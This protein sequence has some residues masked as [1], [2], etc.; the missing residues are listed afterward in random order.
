LAIYW[1]DNHRDRGDT[2]GPILGDALGASVGNELGLLLGELLND[3][4]GKLLGDSLDVADGAE[5]AER[6]G[7]ELGPPHWHWG[8]G[9]A[10]LTIGSLRE[11]DTNNDGKFGDA[12][13]NKCAGVYTLYVALLIH[14]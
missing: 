7:I 13:T 10:A 3:T 12:N 8:G 14:M 1:N 2:L 4:L 9:L 11:D 6:L 5:L